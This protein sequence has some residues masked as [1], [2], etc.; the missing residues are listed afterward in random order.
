MSARTAHARR[1]HSVFIEV[2]PWRVMAPGPD[3]IAGSIPGAVLT[4]VRTDFAGRPT[5]SSGH[6]PLPEQGAVHAGLLAHGVGAADDLVLYT[7]R[8]EELSSAARAWFVLTWAGFRSVR[9]LDGGLPAWSRAGGPTGPPRGTP[10]TAP[11]ADGSPAAPPL[12]PPDGGR[13]VLRAA[14]VLDVADFGTLLDSRPVSAYNGATDDPRTG[15]VPHAVHANSAELVAPDGLLRSPTEIRKW[16]LSRRAIG[17]HEVGAY[18]GGGVS[19]ALLVFAGALL[20]QQ[21]GLFVDSWSA[22]SRD[23]SLPVERGTALTRSAAVDT[24][25]A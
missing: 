6:L 24:D 15:H 22:W 19:S 25:C 18:C 2:A 3:P 1:A 21:V 23:E 12:L 17:G 20:G 13:R 5:A 9:V 7:R 11:S 16:F 14:E 4:S 8:I 10:P